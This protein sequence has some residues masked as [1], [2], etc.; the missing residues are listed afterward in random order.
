M[1]SHLD[2]DAV[3]DYMQDWFWDDLEDS[4]G[5]FLDDDDRELSK[6]AEDNLDAIDEIIG[7]GGSGARLS[8][9]A[10]PSGRRIPGPHRRRW[11]PRPGSRDGLRPAPVCPPVPGCPAARRR[12]R[13]HPDRRVLYAAIAQ[14]LQPNILFYRA[15]RY[16]SAS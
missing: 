5:D 11:R 16:G 1:E 6:E 2:G 12:R 13:R 8:A 10:W 3:A 9:W 4:P 7:D 14:T 15:G